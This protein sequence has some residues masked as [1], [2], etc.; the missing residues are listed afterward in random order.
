MHESCGP[1]VADP[2]LRGGF[3][4][5]LKVLRSQVE[6]LLSGKEERVFGEDRLEDASAKVERIQPDVRA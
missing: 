1:K 5:H 3:E 6:A 2:R 4:A